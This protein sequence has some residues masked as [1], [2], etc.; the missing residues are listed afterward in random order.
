MES[1]K[2]LKKVSV[3]GL[4]S[5]TS[6]DGLDLC[7]VEFE[8]ING[9]WAFQ[10]KA[11]KGLVYSSD[12]RNRLNGAFF[13]SQDELQQLEVDYGAFLGNEASVFMEEN[14]IFD[15]VDLIASHGHT[16]FH[17]PAK[18]I[19]V[20][21]GDGDTIAKLTKKPVVNNFRI[22]DVELGGQG[23][24]L[25]PV[26]DA[27]LFSEF[28][29]CLNLGGIANVSYQFNNERIAFDIAPC[30]LPLNKIMRHN[31]QKE[32]DESGML[33]KS[34]KIIPD[35]LTQLGGLAFYTINPPK[36][37]A[38]EWLNGHFYPI[39]DSFSNDHHDLADILHTIVVHEAAQIAAVLN[40]NRIKTV[41]VTGGG[42]YNT[43]LIDS[44]ITRTNSKIIIPTAEII[45]FKEALIFAF[46]G[47]LNVRGEVNTFKSVTGATHDSTGGFITYP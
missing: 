10:I 45:D 43:F 7:F 17:E 33:A 25:V 35:F 23:A 47:L 18:G 24:P 2:S 41:L 42:T 4:M 19:T 26:G 6:L 1:F 27:F 46:L 13:V 9:E 39:V 34:G 30:N 21:I 32:Y 36:S 20:Q 37:L 22:K 15:E 3:I 29:A 14:G 31:Y 16:I 12:W 38:V 40:Q 5:G 8:Q 44:I 28:D 11:T